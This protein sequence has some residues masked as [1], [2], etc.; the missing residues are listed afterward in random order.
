MSTF[1]A[2]M[3]IEN[4]NNHDEEELLAAWQALVDSGVV[5]KLQGYYGR[6]AMDLINSGRIA[7]KVNNEKPRW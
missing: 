5:W 2:V 7:R 1:E 6:T 4:G 3:I